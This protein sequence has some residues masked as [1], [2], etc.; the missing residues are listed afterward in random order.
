M[1]G[2]LKSDRLRREL[3]GILLTLGL[4][5]VVTLALYGIVEETG[6]QH[7]SVVYLIPVLIAATVW[8]STE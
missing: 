8:W 1:L 3:R 4:V 2:T 5:A 6:L 7:G